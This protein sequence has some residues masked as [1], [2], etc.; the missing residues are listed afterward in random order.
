MEHTVNTKW[1]EHMAFDSHI[2]KHTVRIDTSGEYGDDSGAGPK[3]LLL[4]ALAGCTGMDVVSLFKKMRIPF[5]GLEID[6]TADL[7][8]THPKVYS[9]IR[10]VY[11]VFGHELDQAKVKKAV[12]LSQEKYCGV[13]AMLKKN[14]PILYKIEYAD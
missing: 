8:D 10:L 2:G 4:S 7:T 3:Q 1:K 6:I 14:S 13:S 11:R 5:T 9:E 12:D